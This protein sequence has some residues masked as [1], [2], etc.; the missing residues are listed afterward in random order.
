MRHVLLVMSLL[1][2]A[3]LAEP[4][5]D[6]SAAD[7]PDAAAVS[8]GAYHTC[9]VMSDGGL[10]CWGENSAGQIGDGSTTDRPTPVS[11]SGLTSGVGSV[12]AGFN[13]TCSVSSSGGL[14][15]WGYNY[16]GNVG[17]G[18]TT[19]Q[20]LPVDVVGLGSGVASVS[21]GGS[22]TCALTQAGSIK[23]LGYN[24]YGQLGD[25]STTRRITPVDVAGLNAIAATVSAGENHTCAV[26]AASALKC[27]GYNFSGQVGDGTTTNRAIPIDVPGMD[28]GVLAVAP[29]G[30]HTCALT[31]GGGVKCWGRNSS[32][33]LG[34]GT[35]TD[36]LAPV[37]VTGLSSGVAALVAGFD[38]TC[39]ITSGGGLKCWGENGSGQLGD[40]TTTDR[41]APVDVVGLDSG[42]TAVAPWF[43]HT[44]ALTSAGG[45]KCWGS[46]SSGQLGDGTTADRTIPVDVAFSGPDTDGDGIED[47]S[48]NCPGETNPGQEDLDGDGFGDACD[49]DDDGDGHW[50]SDEAGK[51]SDP[52]AA[53][54]TPEACDGLDNDGDG[55]TDEAPSGADWDIDGDTVKDCLD[56]SV[57]TDGDGAVNTLDGDDD[58]DGAADEDE[59]QMSADGL[60]GCGNGPG[61]DAY[62]PDRDRDHDVD[63]GDVIASFSGRILTPQ[64]YDARSDAGA[65][66]DV[67]IGD[68]ISLFGSG[69]LLTRCAA[70]TFANSAGSVDGIHIEWATSIASVFTARDSGLA[71]WSDRTLSGDGLILDLRRLSGV[72]SG[73]QLTVVVRGGSP[74]VSTCR[75]TLAGADQGPC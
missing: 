53:G 7:T 10:R 9:A 64:R 11:V 39:A 57:D 17:D 34:D 43:G 20:T 2:I 32:G 6:P 41:P 16:W 25:G 67:D 66:G 54:S 27:W 26:T 49:P 24:L 58:G 60:W 30:W 12:D 19:D 28:G 59:R 18:S 33:Q 13:H 5:A 45:V 44:C 71:S 15:C 74:L 47:T 4:A 72:L 61:H 37:D 40:G 31:S 69:K 63:V 8:A 62:P 23:C 75:W 55:G 56:A 48:D 42:V 14:K 38:H 36:R 70:L 46:N 3:S 1:L 68:L 29:A 65:D 21:A 50:D 52:G 35:T 22:H 51:G 73:G